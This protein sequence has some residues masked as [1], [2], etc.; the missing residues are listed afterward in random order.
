[1]RHLADLVEQVDDLELA[2]P[3]PL[4]VVCFRYRPA[5][6]EDETV[7]RLNRALPAAIQR[8][9]RVFIAGTTV[10]G[11]AALRA[12]SVNHRLERSHVELAVEVVRELGARVQ[13]ARTAY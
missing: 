6:A 13:G 1:M 5:G 12:C 10:R 7:D 4:S 8:D 9:G 2:A 3:V 11:R